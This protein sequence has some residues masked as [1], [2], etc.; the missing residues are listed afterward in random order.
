M[1]FGFCSLEQLEIYRS[2]YPM[3]FFLASLV[4][5]VVLLLRFAFDKVLAFINAVLANKKLWMVV[6]VVCICRRD[7]EIA[8]YGFCALICSK[9]GH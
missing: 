8:F 2:P 7:F 3:L 4:G 9:T 6:C 5:I 1:S